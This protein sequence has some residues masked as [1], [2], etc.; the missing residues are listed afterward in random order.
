MNSSCPR[1]RVEQRTRKKADVRFTRN[2]RRCSRVGSNETRSE[3][4]YGRR[5]SNLAIVMAPDTPNNATAPRPDTA[6]ANERC[7]CTEAYGAIGR[8]CHFHSVIH[9]L[10]SISAFAILLDG[11]TGDVTV[12]TEDAAIALER[13]KQL[14]AAFTVVE[15]LTGVRGHLFFFSVATLRA[16]QR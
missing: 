6:Q 7:D 3:L 16:G 13:A 8:S 5:K 2:E 9:V 4:A 1:A 12:R 11:R 15:E 14:T 10:P